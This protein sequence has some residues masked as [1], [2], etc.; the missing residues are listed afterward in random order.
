MIIT[1]KVTIGTETS[2]K[3]FIFAL[4]GK[5]GETFLSQKQ[6]QGATSHFLRLENDQ[7]AEMKVS[8]TLK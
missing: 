5:K 2:S 4:K 8:A 3:T 7:K 6:T 1:L